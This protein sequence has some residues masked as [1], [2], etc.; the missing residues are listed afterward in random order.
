MGRKDSLGI[1]WT[2]QI[3][4]PQGFLETASSENAGC[5]TRTCWTNFHQILLS[6]FHTNTS[7]DNILKNGSTVSSEYAVSESFF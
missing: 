1:G 3:Y 5:Y 4:M 2:S 6:T 7:Y